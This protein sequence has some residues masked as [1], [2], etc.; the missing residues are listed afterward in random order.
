V[1]NRVTDKVVVVFGD[2]DIPNPVFPQRFD[3]GD[4]RC[5]GI[6]FTT[7]HNIITITK[8]ADI[9]QLITQCS[10]LLTGS[11]KERH[12]LGLANSSD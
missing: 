7:F 4:N 9:T 2:L 8:W 5:C 12:R 3:I 10:K 11:Q 1:V 6:T